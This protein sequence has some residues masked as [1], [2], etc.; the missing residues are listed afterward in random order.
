VNADFEAG[1]A[2]DP[3]ELTGNVV[4]AVEAGVAGIS[5][6]DFNK[7]V[8]YEV[9][10]AADRIAVAKEAMRSS[11]ADVLLVAR[12]VGFIRRN[13]DLDDTIARLQAYSR[14]GADCLY[15]PG[16]RDLSAISQIVK[17]V[18]PKPL[19]VLMLGPAFTVA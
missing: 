3:G 11:G 14:A 10:E 13:P 19:N 9:T 2:T 17:A 12:A 6:E 1:Y 7:G 4:A 16:V 5:M 18:A 15:A 8:R